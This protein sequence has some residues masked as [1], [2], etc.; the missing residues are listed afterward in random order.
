MQ[1]RMRNSIYIDSSS[2]PHPDVAGAS[3]VAPEH[4]E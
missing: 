3:R 1:K 4:G 2:Q